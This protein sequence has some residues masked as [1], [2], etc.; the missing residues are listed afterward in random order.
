MKGIVSISIDPETWKRFQLFCIT[1][2][3]SASAMVERLVEK[4]V[5]LTSPKK[6]KLTI[7]EEARKFELLRQSD[8]D[9]FKQL[10]G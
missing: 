1:Q 3:T 4:V 2:N 7:A 5:P 8:P 6:K 9:R 10:E